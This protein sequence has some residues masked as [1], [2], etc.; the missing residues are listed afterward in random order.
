[1]TSRSM[2]AAAIWRCV[3]ISA[4]ARAT[5]DLPEAMGP[6]TRT[7]RHGA[8]ELMSAGPEA[9][10]EV[11]QVL[12][13]VLGIADGGGLAA[14]PQRQELA[15]R[16]LRPGRLPGGLRGAGARERAPVAHHLIRELSLRRREQ[17]VQ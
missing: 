8:R 13:T 15:G 4:R 16:V 7:R 11:A 2:A 1:M 10:P 12:V 17:R 14:G 5:L 6:P 3:R 9:V